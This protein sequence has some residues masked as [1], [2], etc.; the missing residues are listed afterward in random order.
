MSNN[1]SM[2]AMDAEPAPRKARAN[3]RE[4]PSAGLAAPQPI[5]A[6]P[7]RSP[8][9]AKPT[10]TQLLRM[11]DAGAAVN[12]LLQLS[13]HDLPLDQMLSRALDITL[14]LKWLSLSSRG[15]IFLFDAE[16]NMLVMSAHSGLSEPIVRQCATV[17]MGKCLCGRAGLTQ[18]VQFADC[19][20]ARHEVSYEGMAS[21][22]H[23]CVPIVF[24]QTLVGVLNTYLR[25]GH[26]RSPEEERFLEA[27]A[28]AIA[29]VTRRKQAE[30]LLLQS[31]E[32]LRRVFSCIVQVLISA[33]ELRDPYTAGHQRKVADI[34]V[35]I[36]TEMGLSLDRIEAVRIAAAVHDIGKIA[37]PVEILS[38]PGS[39]NEY[40]FAIIKAHAQAGYT[41]LRDV[42]F[43]WPIAQIVLQHH[44][45]IDGSGYPSGLSGDEILLEARIIGVADVLEA[46]CAH[47]PYRPA[48]ELAI[49]LEDILGWR[50]VKYDPAV[51]DAALRIQE[52]G[53][54][55]LRKAA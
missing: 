55:S 23:Y 41:I 7:E 38:K 1:E 53:L 2:G 54:S 33:L 12:A 21:H 52:H 45:R 25:P 49:A 14:S 51:V 29:G 9:I 11:H 32:S 44:E 16:K 19:V 37:V 20:D 36:G 8:V 18:E 26:E 40:E 24:Q 4:R 50:G 10:R 47:R 46:T 6:E 42:E 22:G 43:P 30:V 39:I 31:N 27:N 48:R 3:R 17:Q 28:A 13:L 15:C 35:A 34:A 5:P